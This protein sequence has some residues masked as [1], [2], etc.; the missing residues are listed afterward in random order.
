MKVYRVYDD[1]WEEIMGEK[2]VIEFMTDQILSNFCKEDLK[3]ED[4]D[5]YC[6][7]TDFNRGIVQK[8]FDNKEITLQEAIDILPVRDFYVKEIEIY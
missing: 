8:I 7:T 2:Q 6:Y 4:S 5:I 3:D 1:E